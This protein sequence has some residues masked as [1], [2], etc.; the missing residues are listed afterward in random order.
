L[1]HKNIQYIS[2]FKQISLTTETKGGLDWNV[3]GLLGDY[4]HDQFVG[5]RWE[6]KVGQHG[7]GARILVRA[8][9]RRVDMSKPEVV[10]GLVPLSRELSHEAGFH[11]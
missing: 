9:R 11:L 2:A 7:T 10:H 5:G 1:Q 6:K 8:D 4:G 3:P